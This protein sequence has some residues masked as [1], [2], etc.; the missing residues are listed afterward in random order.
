M[1]VYKNDYVTIDAERADIY[2]QPF[3]E[4]DEIEQEKYR[5]E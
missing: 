1:L 3:T 5:N 2:K 4:T